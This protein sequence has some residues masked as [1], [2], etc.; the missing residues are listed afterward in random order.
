MPCVLLISTPRSGAACL[1]V[2]LKGTPAERML[3][4]LCGVMQ[5]RVEFWFLQFWVNT[6]V[7]GSC[8][9]IHVSTGK[10]QIETHQ[11]IFFFNC[12]KQ[13]PTAELIWRTTKMSCFVTHT[14]ISSFQ[15]WHPPFIDY[16]GFSYKFLNHRWVMYCFGLFSLCH[17]HPHVYH[18]SLLRNRCALLWNPGTVTIFCLCAEAI[19]DLCCWQTLLLTWHSFCGHVETQLLLHMFFLLLFP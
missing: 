3:A 7:V 12:R 16:S 13:R 15:P 8:N 19:F 6:C 9:K 1:C 18:L 14:H 4:R 2:L 11:C 17:P 10:R 5:S